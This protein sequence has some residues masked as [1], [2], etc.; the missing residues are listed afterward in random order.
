LAGTARL[1]ELVAARV[2]AARRL[3][4]DGIDHFVPMRAPERFTA[5]LPA[6]LGQ[7]PAG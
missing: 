1:G 4:L 3:V 7:A 2:P 6:I 5:E